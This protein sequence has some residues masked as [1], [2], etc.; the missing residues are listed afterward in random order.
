MSA[1][2][3]YLPYLLAV[4]IPVLGAVLNSILEFPTSAEWELY[5]IAHPQRARW[6]KILRRLFPYLR[7][8][9]GVAP[10]AA[11]IDEAKKIA[12]EEKKQEVVEKLEEAQKIKAATS[13]KDVP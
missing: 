12:D 2:K 1:L 11:A 9:P 7:R 10:L 4:L 13:K 6:I 5:K 3:P 8:L